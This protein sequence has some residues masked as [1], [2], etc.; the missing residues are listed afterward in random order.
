MS[1]IKDL[2]AYP[3][4]DSR[5]EWTL[6]V[7]VKLKNNHTVA[8]SV[9]KGIS[10]GR[11]E[12][13]SLPVVRAVKN[14]NSVLAKA[15][16][17]LDPLNQE[18]VDEKMMQLDGTSNKSKLGANAILGV[19]L[20][21]ARSAAH[22]RKQPLW[23]YLRSLN[24]RLKT[25]RSFPLLFM[26]MIEGGAHGRNN[27]E[28]QEYLTIPKTTN[29]RNAIEIGTKMYQQLQSYLETNLG[30]Q[31]CGIGDEGAFSPNMP[32]PEAPF[33]ILTELAAKLG[34]EDKVSLGLDAAASE[35]KKSAK[36]LTAFYGTI[37]KK[38]SMLYLEDV[39]SQTDYDNFCLLL[40]SF[41]EKVWITGDDLTVTNLE[42]M[43][44][45]HDKSCVNAV[46]IKP[47]QIGTLSETLHAVERARVYGWKVLVSHRGGETNDDFVADLAYAVGAD[48]FKLGAP[49][50][51]ER[52][53]KYNRL[54]EIEREAGK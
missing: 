20:A 52:I 54:M 50:R 10:S 12:A 17:K 42:L 21:I 30:G 44:K 43:K 19:S 37:V 38:Y 18:R 49:A 3:I 53:A 26:V 16:K 33:R 28:F 45:A 31:A 7:R 4:L 25:A 23:K 13:V 15:V 24:K 35:V 27:L 6:E 5:G 39:F 41:G 40:E 32:S 14:V 29:L 47:S 1:Q 34:L 11:F 51:G 8:A 36:E 46:I 48:G 2:K 9:P 22:L